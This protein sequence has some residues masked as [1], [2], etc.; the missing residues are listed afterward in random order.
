MVF[1]SPTWWKRTNNKVQ[2]EPTCDTWWN[3]KA[4]HHTVVPTQSFSTSP[5]WVPM[6]ASADTSALNTTDTSPS[7]FCRMIVPGHIHR[8]ILTIQ[9]N[10]LDMGFK[11]YIGRDGPVNG[12]G[13]GT[14]TP[15]REQLVFTVPQLSEP[16][17]PTA[18]PHFRFPTGQG[19]TD[20]DTVIPLF[21]GHSYGY[22]IETEDDEIP[23]NTVGFS[24]MTSVYYGA[25]GS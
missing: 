16:G 22:I 17:Y 18:N 19:Q 21:S 1:L 5:A 10:S 25:A 14:G 15:V 12:G 24:I 9:S 13:I 11:V 20:D 6:F 7:A 23:A 3:G 8:I 4:I 2:S